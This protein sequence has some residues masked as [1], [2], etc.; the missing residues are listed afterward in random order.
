[1]AWL[2]ESELQGKKIKNLNYAY[3]KKKEK[4]KYIN[5]FKGKYLKTEF[6]FIFKKQLTEKGVKEL[7]EAA[8]EPPVTVLDSSTL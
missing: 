1:M 2:S 4:R 3:N 5:N 7:S 6:L 8:L